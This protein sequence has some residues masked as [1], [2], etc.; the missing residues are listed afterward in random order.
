LDVKNKIFKKYFLKEFYFLGD[1]SV[2]LYDLLK[3]GDPIR[4]I[5]NITNKSIMSISFDNEDSVIT[6]GTEDYK[7]LFYSLNS[8]LNDD[9][10]L[11]V[12][13]EKDNKIELISQFYTKKTTILVTK[14]SPMNILILLGRF[15][16]NDP[17]IFM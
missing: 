8:I 15:D 13:M 6:I 7:I 1:K 17:K 9:L 11:K 14:F 16:D 2:V 3:M 12:D 5:E 4:I 10:S